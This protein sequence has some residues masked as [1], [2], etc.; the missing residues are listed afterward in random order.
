MQHSTI[1]VACRDKLMKKTPIAYSLTEEFTKPMDM[2]FSEIK[3]SSSLDDEQLDNNGMLKINDHGGRYFPI[4]VVGS[5]LRMPGAN[6]ITEFEKVLVE[7]RSCIKPIP[8]D[9]WHLEDH[10]HEDPRVL[11]HHTITK[12]AFCDK[13]NYFD[14]EFFGISPREA[15]AM[16]PQQ[17]QSLEVAEEAVQ[18]AGYTK[19]TLPKETGV[20]IGMGLMDFPSCMVENRFLYS[21]HTVNGVAHTCSA[22]RISQH[23]GLTGPSMAV[24][25]ACAAALSAMH[26]ACISLWSREIKMAITGASSYVYSPET[27]IG[28]SQLGVLSA[29]GHSAPF[30]VSNNGYVRGEGTGIVLLKPLDDAIRD[31]DHVYCVIRGS[32]SSHNGYCNS[33]TLPSADGQEEVINKCYSYFGIPMES[34]AF[35]EAHGTGT[36]V[37]DPIEATAIGRTLGKSHRGRGPI[38]IQSAKANFGHLE[39]AAGMVQVFKTA[40]ML[41]NRTFYKQINWTEPNPRIDMDE[42]NICIPVKREPYA[43]PNKF[44]IGVNT[45]GFGGALVHM[46]FEEY[47]QQ[48]NSV[49]GRGEV[50]AGWKFGSDDSKGKKI[51]IPLSAKSKIALR[52]TLERWLEWED[53]IDAQSVVGWLAT[54]R[55][56]YIKKRLVILADSGA[57]FRAKIRSCLSDETNEDVIAGS[58]KYFYQKPN[59]CFV[60]PGW[61]QQ[62]AQMGRS[63]YKNSPVFKAAVQECDTMFRKIS[64]FSALERFD[65]FADGVKNGNEDSEEADKKRYTLAIL[66]LQIGLT[67]LLASWGVKPDIVIGTGLGEHTAAL[68]SGAMTLEQTISMLHIRMKQ[69]PK[70][71]FIKESSNIVNGSK[72]TTARFF[73]TVTGKEHKGNL[74]ANYWWQ[75]IVCKLQAEA[76]IQSMLNEHDDVVFIELSASPCVQETFPFD[77]SRKVFSCCQK[78]EDDWVS[79]LR[80][81]AA[82]HVDGFPV[83]W[84]A[85]TEHSA[86]YARIPLY[87]F[88]DKFFQL[89]SQEYTGRRLC[90]VKRTFRNMN[91]RINMQTFTSLRDNTFQDEPIFPAASYIEYFSEYVESKLAGLKDVVI[92]KNLKLIPLT[93]EGHTPTVK[94]DMKQKN[95]RLYAVTEDKETMAFATIAGRNSV[96]SVPKIDIESIKSKCKELKETDGIYDNF[97]KRGMCLG[98]CFKLIQ[99]IYMAELEAVAVC[100]APYSR[101]RYE[102]IQGPVLESAFQTAISAFTTGKTMYLTRQVGHLQ[103]FLEKVPPQTAFSVYALLKEYSLQYIVCDMT[104]VGEDGS[105]WLTVDDFRAENVVPLVTDVDYSSCCYETKWQPDRAVMTAPPDLRKTMATIDMTNAEEAE[106]KLD[107]LQKLVASLSKEA[108]SVAGNNQAWAKL[109]TLSQMVPSVGSSE[110]LCDQILEVAPEISTEMSHLTNLGEK[111]IKNMI[112]ESLSHKETVRVADFG[113]KSAVFTKLLAG[114]L[115]EQIESIRVEYSFYSS[116]EDAFSGVSEY[117]SHFPAI[118]YQLFEEGSLNDARASFDL[119]VVSDVSGTMSGHLDEIKQ[120]L[121]AGGTVVLLKN[122]RC[123]F[124]YDFLSLQE[125]LTVRVDPAILKEA[126]FDNVTELSYSEKSAY[127]VLMGQKSVLPRQRADKTYAIVHESLSAI[128]ERICENLQGRAN[129]Y[130]TSEFTEE[131]LD[132]W[133]NVVV[134]YLMGEQPDTDMGSD[135]LT[136]LNTKPEGSVASFYVVYESSRGQTEI[137]GFVEMIRAIGSIGAF[138]VYSV[139]VKNYQNEAAAIAN[140]VSRGNPADDQ[141][142]IDGGHLM[143]P[144]VIRMNAYCQFYNDKAWELRFASMGEQRAARFSALSLPLAK[145]E[146][147]IRIKGMAMNEEASEAIFAYSGVVE[148]NGPEATEFNIGEAVMGLSQMPLRSHVVSDVKTVYPMPSELSWSD[149]A[150]SLLSYI[151]VYIALVDQA[152]MKSGQTLLIHTRNTSLAKAAALVARSKGVKAI[153][154]HSGPVDSARLPWS[155]GVLAVANPINFGFHEDMMNFTNNNGVDVVFQMGEALPHTCIDVLACGVHVCNVGAR[156]TAIFNIPNARYSTLHL[157]SLATRWQ[158][159]IQERASLVTSLLDRGSLASIRAES[160]EF[161]DVL[162]E[163]EPSQSDE[164]SDRALVFEI[165]DDYRPPDIHSIQIRFRSKAWYVVVTGHRL[166]LALEVCRWLAEGGAAHIALV[167][168]GGEESFLLKATEKYVN[169]KNGHLYSVRS[170][171]ATKQQVDDAIG[172]IRKTCQHPISG[173]FHLNDDGT[174]FTSDTTDQIKDFFSSQVGSIQLLEEATASMNMDHFVVFASAD[175]TWCNHEVPTRTAVARIAAELCQRGRSLGRRTL[176]VELGQIR[177]AGSPAEEDRFVELAEKIGSKSLHFDEYLAIIGTLLQRDDL[178][179]MVTITHQNWDKTKRFVGGTGTLEVP[180]SVSGQRALG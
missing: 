147:K 10:H 38:K 132:G 69:A 12:L 124:I 100:K 108:V 25:T 49:S 32:A 158:D 171:M 34:I 51:P 128:A 17:T 179:A 84:S 103:M 163:L 19:E 96:E 130:T 156:R 29:T 75:N 42:L 58:K 20:F 5:G 111:L 73:S 146:M 105:V 39:V 120:L 134:L 4:A 127:T 26:M 63:L 54:R 115:Q 117:L 175:G 59:I 176:C 99:K 154:M 83:D 169:S 76:P 145:S 89:E 113:E 67:R 98:R 28:F 159:K 129:I 66:F 68:A 109:E 170:D 157:S 61:G 167:S 33:I 173:I 35:I 44:L 80:V 126:G 48:K 136:L 162:Y 153:F 174:E 74:D 164:A 30:D 23:Y 47:R 18:D 133:S 16:D 112:D 165:P 64:G 62:H 178:P 57:D 31:S 53:E 13:M 40:L 36:P 78:D 81:M 88:D 140:A 55:E 87:G 37:G 135:V 22:N 21:A 46:V 97:E 119:V 50:P 24:D 72:P 150:D 161:C 138:P 41:E 149:A 43:K 143:V 121:R 177:G 160:R 93:P 79:A 45:F 92:K 1:S 90:L 148:E 114:V 52:N 180:T 6:N 116:E 137:H 82:L 166:E 152:N 14:P 65:I 168:R 106:G 8:N 2:A 9:R 11:G 142:L 110:S 131:P 85:I 102:R 94:L 15:Y 56:H 77:A 86:T 144:R 123:Q 7:E 141:F 27:T 60:Y 70:E 122:T 91:G 104:I 107:I 3:V 118:K 71:D 151:T 101:T 139:G 125:A 172:E 95:M 155:M